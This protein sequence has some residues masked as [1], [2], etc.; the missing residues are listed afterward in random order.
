[1]IDQKS[2][3]NRELVKGLVLLGLGAVLFAFSMLTFKSF[4]LI[5]YHSILEGIG[6]FLGVVGIWNLV[7]YLRYQKNPEIAK[8]ARVESTD[9]RQLLIKSRS[10]NNAFKVGVTATYLA[11]LFT[12]AT[13]NVISSDIAWW[14][15]AAI[16]VITLLVYIVSII[17]FEKLY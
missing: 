13:E 3:L 5:P 15:L 14:V 8:K 2:K 10:G 6:L 4:L 16:V 17:R 11:L 1:M 7:Q 12:G 9:E